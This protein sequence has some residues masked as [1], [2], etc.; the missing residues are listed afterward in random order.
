MWL[1]PASSDP[2]PVEVCVPVL[3]QPVAGR[4]VA[5]ASPGARRDAVSH[6]ST[7]IEACDKE[8]R[9][10]SQRPE[11]QPSPRMVAM[12]RRL[13]LRRPEKD[14]LSHA[15]FPR[16]QVAL[17]HDDLLGGGVNLWWS[18]AAGRFQRKVGDRSVHIVVHLSDVRDA[19]DIWAWGR[20][21]RPAP[22]HH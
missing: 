17:A 9:E 20:W 22:S 2:K 7:A 3:L 11:V 15:V 8:V 18:G 4:G 13:R 1:D 6:L 5:L 19:V 21:W 12:G 10:L 14:I 16:V